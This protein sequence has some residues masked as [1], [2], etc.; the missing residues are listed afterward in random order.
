[1]NDGFMQLELAEEGRKLSTFYTHCGPERFKRLDFE[2]DSAAEI[3]NLISS[4]S[5]MMS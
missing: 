1:M 2:V 4:A 5:M 3:V